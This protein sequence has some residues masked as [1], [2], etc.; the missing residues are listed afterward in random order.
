MCFSTYG[1]KTYTKCGGHANEHTQKFLSKYSHTFSK[2]CAVSKYGG[3]YF[4][5]EKPILDN[6]RPITLEPLVRS[7]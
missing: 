2:Y 3:L 6:H 5:S 7:I 1:N 4:Y